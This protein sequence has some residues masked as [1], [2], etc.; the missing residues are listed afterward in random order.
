M[1]KNAVQSHYR[2]SDI[3][4]GL[5]SVL[6]FLLAGC[7]TVN[8][9]F[10]ESAVQKAA[11]DFVNDLYR[12]T[13]SKKIN[14]ETT[15]NDRNRSNDTSIIPYEFFISSANADESISVSTPKTAAI[16]SR[17][18]SR[19]SEIVDYKSKGFLGES[20]DGLLVLKESPGDLKSKAALQRLIQQENSD[21][22]ELYVEVQM[23]NKLQDQ[24]QKRIR[25]HFSSAFQ[26]HS[27]AGSWVQKDNGEWVKK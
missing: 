2:F 26:L 18:A 10:P 11:D 3:F 4:K 27:P 19:V 22:N 23:A 12:E 16:K 21:R 13:E 7:I 5:S 15:L 9:Y 20:N 14:K 24:G 17:M 25:A 6:F 8:V 1:S